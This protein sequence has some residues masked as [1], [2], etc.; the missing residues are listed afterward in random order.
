MEELIKQQTSNATALKSAFDNFKKN[1]SER[2]IPELFIEHRAKIESFWSL[3]V[4]NDQQIKQFNEYN[5][6]EYKKIN[7]YKQA[8]K[9]CEVYRE[10][11]DAFQS[12]YEKR[13]N[14]STA[15]TPTPTPTSTPANTTGAPDN[16]STNLPPATQPGASNDNS[17]STP[18]SSTDATNDTMADF[19]REQK[20]RT[21]KIQQLQELIGKI[22]NF[23]A[24]NKSTQF[25][26][27]KAK[28]LETFWTSILETTEAMM[29]GGDQYGD[30][31]KS[32]MTQIQDNYDAAIIKIEEL[33][34]TTTK[35]R[36]VK[37]PQLNIPLFDGNYLAWK[38][39]HD[40]F[41]QSVF[42]DNSISSVEKF[43]LLKTLVKGEASQIIKHL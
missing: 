21:L 8:E 2:R 1:P 38:S 32:E 4:S 31:H 27:Q 39:F 25:L 34:A 22:D 33:K 36:S 11:I 7:Y 26:D 19:S 9:L 17:T 13:Q 20:K 3:F 14:K 5:D 40:L 42:K 35:K 15:P 43:Q 30:T 23:I 12:E 10:K 6:S 41:E 16:N 28:Q 18:S 29:N 37:L 24:E